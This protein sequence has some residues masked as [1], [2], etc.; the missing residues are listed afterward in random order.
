MRQFS[1]SLHE[2]REEKITDFRTFK[3]FYGRQ[4]KFLSSYPDLFASFLYGLGNNLDIV[5]LRFGLHIFE[6]TDTHPAPGLFAPQFGLAIVCVETG[7]FSECCV[8]KREIMHGVADAWCLFPRRSSIV[9]TV[10]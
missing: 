10:A 3:V 4:S 5:I 8:F 9:W 2:T 7:F 6:W 1:N